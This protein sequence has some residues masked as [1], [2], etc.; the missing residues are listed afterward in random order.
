VTGDSHQKTGVSFV[1][2]WSKVTS[3]DCDRRY[4]AE[5]EFRDTRFSAQK[6]PDQGFVIWDVGGYRVLGEDEAMIQ[7]ATDEQVRYR[8]RLERDTLTFIDA[9]GCEFSYRR[10]K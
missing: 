5:I 7:I 9:D 10:V 4:P 2:R 8:Y 3:S 1:G 6:A